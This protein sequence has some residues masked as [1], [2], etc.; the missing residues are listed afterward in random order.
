MLCCRRANELDLDRAESV[1]SDFTF[2]V[3]LVY[4]RQIGLLLS[5]KRWTPVRVLYSSRVAMTPTCRR[6]QPPVTIS[7]R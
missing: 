5:R 2:E 3:N 6:S 4:P 1:E 7:N